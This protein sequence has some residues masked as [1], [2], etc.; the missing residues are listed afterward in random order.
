[1]HIFHVGHNTYPNP[2]RA[3]LE[4]PQL[5]Q[6]IQPFDAGDLV[7]DEVQ[8]AQ[9]LEVRDVL[10]VLDL[11]EAEVEAGQV[12]EVVEALD[13]GDEVVVEV[14]FGEGR[15]EVRGEGDVGDLVLA[16]ADFL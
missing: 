5:R 2:I 9:L 15:A 11:V 3:Q 10:D 16:G 14:E 12:G 4:I 1:M 7:L 13:V 8:I 6:P